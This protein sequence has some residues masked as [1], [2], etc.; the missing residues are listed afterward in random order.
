MFS[1]KV[2]HFEVIKYEVKE[3]IIEAQIQ[4][5]KETSK[6]VIPIFISRKKFEEFLSDRGKLDWEL[7]SEEAGEHIQKSGTIDIEDY[8]I[9]SHPY[10]YEDLYEF[11]VSHPIVFRNVLHYNSL[12]SILPQL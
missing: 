12:T 8:Y 6:K 1:N 7:N 3:C 2:K 11:I 4:G 9:D 10:I 5:L